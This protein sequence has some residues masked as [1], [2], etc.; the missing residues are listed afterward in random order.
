MKY[1]QCVHTRTPTTYYQSSAHS[2]CRGGIRG[3]IYSRSFSFYHPPRYRYTF[4]SQRNQL[5]AQ[6][7]RRSSRRNA[8]KS[9]F[10]SSVPRR[11]SSPATCQVMDRAVRGNFCVFFFVLVA[12]SSLL[13]FYGK[14]KETDR[15]IPERVYRSGRKVWWTLG[16]LLCA[17]PSRSQSR[18]RQL[19][20][21]VTSKRI[22][23]GVVS[24]VW[25]FVILFAIYL[26]ESG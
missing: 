11:A 26:L 21:C 24:R 22:R 8:S 12:R 3:R 25:V 16:L 5:Q 6:Q 20:L 10:V 19:R 2:E 9:S 14:K 1:R 4:G 17:V 18:R 23:R 13:S 7:R 15:H